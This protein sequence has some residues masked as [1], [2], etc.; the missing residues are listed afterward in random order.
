MEHA[1][2]IPDSIRRMIMD[3]ALG[4]SEAVPSE[5]LIHFAS[6]SGWI[7][8]MS[9]TNAAYSYSKNPPWN[10]SQRRI[11][12]HIQLDIFRGYLLADPVRSFSEE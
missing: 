5:D 7:D 10:E 11:L 3:L 2:P 1:N 8:S 9:R 6:A 4:G 12:R